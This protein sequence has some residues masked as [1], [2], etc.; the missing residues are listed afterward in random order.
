M[1]GTLSIFKL[2]RFFMLE[3][4]ELCYYK[5]RFLTDH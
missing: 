3:K 2:I 1:T 4:L 5:M